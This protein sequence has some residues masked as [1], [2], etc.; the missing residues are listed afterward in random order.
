[1]KEKE[2]KERDKGEDYFDN[3]VHTSHRNLKGVP[4]NVK[5]VPGMW[6][7]PALTEF[8]VHAG[9]LDTEFKDFK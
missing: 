9:F 1:M 5:G 6:H 4:R 7:G 3:M 8:M 2:R